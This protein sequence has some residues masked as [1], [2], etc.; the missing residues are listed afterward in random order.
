MAFLFRLADAGGK[1]GNG[2][3]DE[4]AHGLSPSRPGNVQAACGV[5]KALSRFSNGL[6]TR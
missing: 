6:I 5:K 2:R 3:E 1:G 4:F